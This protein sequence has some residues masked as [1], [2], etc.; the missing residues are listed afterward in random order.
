VYD[1]KV[2]E[3]TPVFASRV[4]PVGSDPAEIE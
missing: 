4:T 2:P 1:A 3:M